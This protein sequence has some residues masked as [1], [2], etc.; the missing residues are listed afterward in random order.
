MVGQAETPEVAV[1]AAGAEHAQAEPAVAGVGD[2]P[3]DPPLAGALNDHQR[4]GLD[5]VAERLTTPV[6]R[7]QAREQRG[8]ADHD[9]ADAGRPRR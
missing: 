6:V 9:D 5:A 2:R 8:R 1:Q 4:I 7:A 3:V